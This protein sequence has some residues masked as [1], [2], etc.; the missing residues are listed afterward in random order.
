M[1]F[2]RMWGRPLAQKR[3]DRVKQEADP[4]LSD[5]ADA[6]SADYGYKYA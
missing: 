1:N 3:R 6:G 4:A 5:F 2:M